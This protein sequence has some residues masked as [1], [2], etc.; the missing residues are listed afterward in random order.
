MPEGSVRRKVLR[1]AKKVLSPEFQ[2]VENR[3]VSTS[4]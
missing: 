3:Y 1:A 2:F 4:F